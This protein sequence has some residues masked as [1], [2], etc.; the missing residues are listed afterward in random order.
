M[1][2][3]PIAS[4]PQTIRDVVFVCKQLGQ[5]YLWVD[6][7]CI[8]QDDPDDKRTQIPQMADIYSGAL[9]AIS[10]AGSLGVL[11]GCPLGS[12][13]LQPVQPQVFELGYPPDTQ[14]P[15]GE[16]PDRRKVMTVIERMEHERCRNLPG[17]WA[18]ETFDQDTRDL[19]N[20]IEERAWTFQERFLAKRTLFIGKGE[21]SWT[22]ASEVKCECRKS[23]GSQG[24]RRLFSYRHNNIGQVTTDKLFDSLELEKTYSFLWADMVTAYSARSLT[25]FGDRVAA[26]EGI[27]VAFQTRWPH[28]YNK[29]DYAFGCW[30]PFLA[31][32]LVWGASGQPVS[33]EIDKDL[34]PSWAWPSC[35][36]P[37]SF[38]SWVWYGVDPKIWVQVLD[39]EIEQ[40]DGGG[41]AFGHGKGTLT[42]RGPLIPVKGEV[43][44][45]EDDID[46]VVFTP[47]DTHLSFLKGA[48]AFDDPSNNLGTGKTVT[49]MIL[50]AS[51]PFKLQKRIRP[52]SCVL[53][54]VA[55][56]PGRDNEFRRLGIRTT[57]RVKR[58]YSG[59]DFQELF[60]PHVTNFRLI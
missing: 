29:R 46:E 22:C 25:Q 52:L 5:L 53:L 4:L 55:P 35:G 41:A 39:L 2:G 11:E 10:A 32:L 56:V 23:D 18:H 40:P 34:F 24:N 49:H 21:M 15:S 26:L 33:A 37:V 36:R 3:I 20:P 50:L 13:A 9:L 6:A 42:M 19:L 54:C 8:I 43:I 7:L 57:P 28:V 60:S 44:K 1:T 58:D 51:Y 47:L 17:H 48:P 59:F 38:T 45:F 16:R 30:R 31:D 12:V 14:G 27:S